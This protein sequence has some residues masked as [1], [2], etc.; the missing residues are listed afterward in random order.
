MN[1]KYIALSIIE[2]TACV[3]VLVAWVVL[4][5]KCLEREIAEGKTVIAILSLILGLAIGTGI[6]AIRHYRRKLEK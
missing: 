5:V 6:A 1:K 4:T 3:G 2:L